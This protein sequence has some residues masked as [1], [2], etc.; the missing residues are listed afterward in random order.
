MKDWNDVDNLTNGLVSLLT[1]SILYLND[2]VYDYQVRLQEVFVKSEYYRFTGKY[3]YNK[4]ERNVKSYNH[5]IKFIVKDKITDYANLLIEVDE[6]H[7]RHIDNFY[8]AVSQCLLNGGIG[9]KLNKIQSI[10]LVMDMLCQTVRISIEAFQRNVSDKLRA[11]NPTREFDT[12]FIDRPVLELSDY[13]TPKGTIINLNAN[14]SV[15][16]AFKVFSDKLLSMETIK[17]VM[18]KE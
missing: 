7:S 8:F 2:E 15:M 4:I 18:E 17:A 9:G 11:N 6:V 1:F 13:L 12:T 14:K 5:K 16:E 3:L 10:L